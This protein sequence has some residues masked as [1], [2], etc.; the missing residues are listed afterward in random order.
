[1]GDNDF[2]TVTAVALEDPVN[3][4]MMASSTPTGRRGKFYDICTRIKFNQDDTL[5]PINTK[6]L[7][8]VYDTRKY[9]RSESYGWKEFYFPTYVNPNWS[10]KME[11]E[12]REQYSEVGYQ[13]EV[14]AEFGTETVGVFN[15][16]YVDEAASIEYP[17]EPKRIKG[18]PISIGV[19]WDKYGATTNIVV[20]QYDPNDIRRA[21]PETGQIDNGF[22]RF[23]VLNHI[24]IPK[25]D[26]QYDIAVQTVQELDKK[27][28]PFAIRVDRGAGEFQLEMLRKTLGEKVKGVFYGESVEVRDPVS[29]QI[30]KKSLK[31]LLINQ[32][33]LLLERGQLRIPNKDI[34]ETIHRQMINFRVVR[35]SS[36][37][38]EPVYTNE[39]EHGLDAYIFGMTAFIDEYPNLINIIDEVRVE[40]KMNVLQQR[41][42]NAMAD[43][44]KQL[45]NGIDK[46]DK[47]NDT[48]NNQ[49]YRK[50]P[51]GFTK[52]QS[53]GS[54]NKMGWGN[55][56]NNA[57]SIWRN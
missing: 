42:Y 4:G 56:Q 31:P 52:R 54:A 51:L 9:D 8:Y 41:S 12:L 34:S 7:G 37:T 6:E 48:P 30:E 39:D 21:R 32:M 3:I 53:S 11:K 24:E 25:S 49:R 5:K 55:N 50:V 57:K 23:K 38:M 14:L 40:T 10:T 18:G 16:D 44:E 2:E 17:L 33:T 26:M 28:D 20:V 47:E 19:D 22:G 1:M 29:N 13:H 27:Y 43:V 45:K 15:K 36:K 46:D 35:V